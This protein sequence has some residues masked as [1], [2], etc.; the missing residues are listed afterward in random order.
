MG[1]H[2]VEKEEVPAITFALHLRVNADLSMQCKSTKM[3]SDR[4]YRVLDNCQGT[5][6]GLKE[7]CSHADDGDTGRLELS[8]Y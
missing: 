4:I 6:A 7:T 1:L 8:R 3:K 5:K 2:G